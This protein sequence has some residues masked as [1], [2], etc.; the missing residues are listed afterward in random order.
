MALWFLSHLGREL[1][2]LESD[3]IYPSSAS[4]LAMTPNL[5]CPP[6]VGLE[7]LQFILFCLEDLDPP[8]LFG[9]HLSLRVTSLGKTSVAHHFGHHP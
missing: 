4:S 8:Y 1:T 3:L 9:E 2:P 5:P 6:Q 7:Q